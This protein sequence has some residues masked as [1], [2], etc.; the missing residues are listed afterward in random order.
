ME[1]DWSR[2]WMAVSGRELLSGQEKPT[3]EAF[4]LATSAD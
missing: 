3:V 1:V 2:F 4:P